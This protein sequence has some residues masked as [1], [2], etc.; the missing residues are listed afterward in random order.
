MC[1]AHKSGRLGQLAIRNCFIFAD[2]L[3]NTNVDKSEFGKIFYKPVKKFLHMFCF[4]N[5]ISQK[6]KKY[7]FSHS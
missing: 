6:M 1:Y 3:Q 5:I 4:Q 2:V 7:I